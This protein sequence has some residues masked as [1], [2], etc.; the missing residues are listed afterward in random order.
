[1]VRLRLVVAGWSDIDGGARVVAGNGTW[2]VMA[3]EFTT[4]GNGRRDDGLMSPARRR[5][6]GVVVLHGRRT[7]THG[8]GYGVSSASSRDEDESRS[9]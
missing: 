5:K 1:V 2:K 9:C 7:E 4:E 8:G 3:T 6:T